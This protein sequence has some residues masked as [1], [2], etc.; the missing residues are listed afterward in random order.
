MEK[1]LELTCPNCNA[2]LHTSLELK[3]AQATPTKAD[4][5][6]KLLFKV[7]KKKF[8][9]AKLEE[10]RAKINANLLKESVDEVLATLTPREEKV[11]KMRFGLHR[12]NGLEHTLQEI[13]FHFARSGERIRQI[14]NRILEKLRHPSRSKR[15]EEFLKDI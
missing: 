12:D 3:V 2:L 9:N 4:Q 11:I 1:V 7:F 5:E 10:Y 14:E 8:S 15:L 6:I 13:G